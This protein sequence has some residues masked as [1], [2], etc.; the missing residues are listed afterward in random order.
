MKKIILSIVLIISFFSSYGQTRLF[1]DPEFSKHG[2]DHEIIVVIPFETTISLRPKKIKELK[3]GQL[4]KMQQNESYNI[5]QSMYSWFLKR[6]QQGKLWVEVQDVNKTNA[7]LKK[8]GISYS[9]IK[10]FTAEE[11]TAILGVDAVING[12]FETNK[13]MS[14]GVGDALGILVGFYGAT[15]RATINMFIHNADDGKIL[16]NYNKAVSGSIGSSTDQLINI[17]MRKA[18]RRIPYTKPKE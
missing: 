14:D 3:E 15:N 10:D 18:S 6:K 13:P 7:L 11:I 4:E 5:Q 8:E 12:R 1:V 17:I 16:V 9:N 2:N